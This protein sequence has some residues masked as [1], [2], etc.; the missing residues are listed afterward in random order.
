MFSGLV[1]PQNRFS[2]KG[3]STGASSDVF[4]PDIGTMISIPVGD[5]V[6]H[7]SLVDVFGAAIIAKLVELTSGLT[8]P[9]LASEFTKK[10]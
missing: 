6:T 9:L 5:Y 10:C 1:G 4:I 7:E 8:R 3:F 2:L